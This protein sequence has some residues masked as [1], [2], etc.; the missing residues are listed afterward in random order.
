MI[1]V[2]QADDDQTVP[3]SL[4][5]YALAG[6]CL[7]VV[8][9]CSCTGKPAGSGVE[10]SAPTATAEVTAPDSLRS[11]DAEAN[12]LDRFVWTDFH[13]EMGGTQ[14]FD[15]TGRHARDLFHDSRQATH[16]GQPVT[17]MFFR[18][19]EYD[20]TDA[21]LAALQRAAIAPSYWSLEP[22]YTN[23]DIEDGSTQTFT[24]WA[25]KRKK[26]VVCYQEW[27]EPVGALRE[28]VSSIQKSHAA[29]RKVAVEV[30]HDLGEQIRADAVAAGR[31]AGRGTP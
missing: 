20:L 22:R 16:Q 24:V 7:V 27:P 9:A 4:K 10:P 3:L 2:S 30:G 13:F 5:L 18:L 1:S 12:R 26:D 11:A 14:V 28:V 19:A 17:Q 25:G 31:A 15:V 29:E 8:F 23:K 21:E 6:P